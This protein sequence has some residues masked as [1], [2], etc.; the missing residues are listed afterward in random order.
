MRDLE[1][2]QKQIRSD[3]ARLLDDIEEHAGML[4]DD[5]QLAKLRETAQAFAAAVRSSGASE[6]MTDA[7]DALGLVRRHA[8]VRECQEGR[9]YPGEVPL[10]VLVGWEAF[11]QACQGSLAFQPG[12]AH[13]L[14][15]FDRADARGCRVAVARPDRQ[16]RVRHRPGTGDGY[17]ARQNNMNN[18]G[19]YGSLPTLVSSPRQGSGRARPFRP[20]GRS[21]GTTVAPSR[22]RARPP[23][24]CRGRSRPIPG[25][26]PRPVPPPGR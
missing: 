12:L 19:L 6:A 21:Q 4:P 24:R 7:E 16:T 1:A 2:E 15:Q 8:F 22:P 11:G 13:N 25:R 26:H 20:A 23:A 3:L 5:P 18:V 10:S 17:S 14:G 9:R